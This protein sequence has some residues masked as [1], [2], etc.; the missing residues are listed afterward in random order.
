MHRLLYVGIKTMKSRELILTGLGELDRYVSLA[1]AAVP[2]RNQEC[3]AE[4]LEI[5]EQAKGKVTLRR[6]CWAP[7]EALPLAPAQLCTRSWRRACWPEAQADARSRSCRWRRAP[8]C[9]RRCA[10]GRSLGARAIRLEVRQE[11]ERSARLDREAWLRV[12]RTAPRE[13]LGKALERRWSTTTP[14]LD[15]AGDDEQLKTDIEVVLG[16]ASSMLRLARQASAERPGAG[17]EAAG[18][19]R[20]G[21]REPPVPARDPPVRAGRAD[22]GRGPATQASV[23]APAEPRRR[24]TAAPT[25]APA[26]WRSS[27]C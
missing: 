2:L 3:S 17:R 20:G 4:E 7:G 27:T 21:G 18:S 23:G 16:R 12:S 1:A 19:T 9:S 25:P 15:A 8:S 6:L 10:S 26:T 14:L 13:E 22:A 24:P 11:L 5:M